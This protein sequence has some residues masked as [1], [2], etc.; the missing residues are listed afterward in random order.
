M[1]AA[2]KSGPEV[3]AIVDEANGKVIVGVKHNG[4]VLPVAQ[5]SLDYAV[6]RDLDADAPANTD[7]DTKGGGE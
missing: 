1:A 3:V 4:K 7:D 2:K 5:A 6:S